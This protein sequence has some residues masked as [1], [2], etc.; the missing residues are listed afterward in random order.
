MQLVSRLWI[1]IE[2]LRREILIKPQA[3]VMMTYQK[4][5]TQLALKRE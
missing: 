4:T 1:E 5:S 2:A 3:G